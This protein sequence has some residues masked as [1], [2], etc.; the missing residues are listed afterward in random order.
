M[1]GLVD[2][3][4]KKSTGHSQLLDTELFI[5][6]SLR[7]GVYLSAFV[8][9]LGLILLFVRGSSGYPVDVFPTS[10]AAL[11]SGI[12][13]FKAAAIITLGLVI[14]IVTPVFRV[15]ASVLLFLVE[16]DHLY[17]MITLFVLAILI[18]SFLIGKAF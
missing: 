5:S 6:Y 13:L 8:M 17:T 4:S 10:I 2:V 1:E 3:M 14:L 18:I 7:F 12:V 9:A 11:W 15:A 16:K